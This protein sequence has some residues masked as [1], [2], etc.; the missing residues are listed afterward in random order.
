MRVLACRLD[1]RTPGKRG[2]NVCM[3]SSRA[4]QCLEV[5]SS[6]ERHSLETGFKHAMSMGTES[7]SEIATRHSVAFVALETDKPVDSITIDD[8]PIGRAPR[9]LLQVV[10]DPATFAQPGKP[11]PQGRRIGST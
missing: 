1:F 2:P 8:L 11:C 10:H 5:A 6:D 4:R 7:R 9:P 3:R